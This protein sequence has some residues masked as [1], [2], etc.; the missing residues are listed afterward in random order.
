[1][2][3]G[4]LNHVLNVKNQVL[5]LGMSVYASWDQNVAFLPYFV[6]LQFGP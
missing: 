6:K 3:F 4:C 1:M 5:G 2:G